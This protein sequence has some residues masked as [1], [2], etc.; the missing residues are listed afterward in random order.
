MIIKTHTRLIL[1]ET[2]AARARELGIEVS[3]PYP[4]T[5]PEGVTY[6]YTH[7]EIPADLIEKVRPTQGASS[8]Q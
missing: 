8:A 6:V 4:I 1:T 7:A 5:S 2:E 3:G